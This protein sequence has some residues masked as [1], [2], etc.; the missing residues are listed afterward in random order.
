MINDNKIY[1]INDKLKYTNL[2]FI[3]YSIMRNGNKIIKMIYGIGIPNI[4][5]CGIA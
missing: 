4:L 2:L 5:N 3:L 1:K